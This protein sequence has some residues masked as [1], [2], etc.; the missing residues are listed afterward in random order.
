MVGAECNCNAASVRA[1]APKEAINLRQEDAITQRNTG[2]PP[3]GYT[4]LRRSSGND[5]SDDKPPLAQA[6]QLEPPSPGWTG[7][8]RGRFGL[9][10]AIVSADYT[11]CAIMSIPAVPDGGIL[12]TDQV[13]NEP[14][15]R[16]A[17]R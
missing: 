3:S 9:L 7:T 10:S 6:N 13:T 11:P 1:Q 12:Q 2:L 8:L 16:T 15:V 4:A 14:T 5:R 17:C